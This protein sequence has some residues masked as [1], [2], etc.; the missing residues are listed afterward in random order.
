MP[1]GSP[2]QLKQMLAGGQ[3]RVVD[4]GYINGHNA[5]ELRASL[6]TITLEVRVDSQTYQPVRFIKSV[7]RG[8]GTLVFDEFWIARTPAL[9]SITSHPQIP[10]GFTRVPAPK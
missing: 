1:G 5:T 3:M 8:L 4:H 6:G 10:A 9:V 7:G 2:A